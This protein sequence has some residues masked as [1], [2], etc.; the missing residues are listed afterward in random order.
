MSGSKQNEPRIL[1]LLTGFGTGC[2]QKVVTRIGS[3]HLAGDQKYVHH[4][5][6]RRLKHCWTSGWTQSEPKITGWL[7]KFATICVLKELSQN[8]SVPM[9]EK[10]AEEEEVEEKVEEP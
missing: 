6:A 7:T 5:A 4:L 1:Q 8:R 10:V 2:V 3:D 9:I